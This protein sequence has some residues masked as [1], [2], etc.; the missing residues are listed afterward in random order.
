MCTNEQKITEKIFDFA[1]GAAL[2]DAIR[3][4]AF[5]SDN[6]GE[7]TV[8]KPL[9][10][11]E[12]AREA[13]HTY[14]TAVLDGTYADDA[15]AAE[16]N[17]YDTAEL[18]EQAFARRKEEYNRHPKDGKKIT[19]TFR[20][21][22]AQKLINMTA[23]YLF[24]L[25]Y[26][27]ADLR[28]NFRHCHC[29]MDSIM[30][31]HVIGKIRDCLNEKLPLNEAV[32]EIVANPKW[33][34]DLRQPWSKIEFEQREQYENYQKLIAFLAGELSPIEYDYQEWKSDEEDD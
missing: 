18:V 22:N 27:R 1:Y 3:Q 33:V 5:K 14:I 11:C 15:G 28:K 20:F 4:Q 26:D 30:V 16:R 29:P 13:V 21:G 12:E 9:R 23:K 31:E 34:S 2:E 32:Q 24:I 7:S 25:T 19:G 10:K 6:K 8:K 17:F